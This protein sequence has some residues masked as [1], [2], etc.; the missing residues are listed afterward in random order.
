MK[1]VIDRLIAEE[2]IPSGYFDNLPDPAFARK[3]LALDIELGNVLK[4]DR[5][6]H[7]SIAY[8]GT[9]RLTSEDKRR[10]YGDLGVIPNVTQGDRFVQVDS[11]FAKPDE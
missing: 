5:H 3:G 9:Q 1:L 11:A 8:H 6:G 7:V 10:Q 4:V 2:G